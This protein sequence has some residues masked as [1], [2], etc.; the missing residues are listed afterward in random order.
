MP[1]GP[2]TI[3]TLA[4][5]LTREEL[6]N[7]WKLA[8]KQREAAYARLAEADKLLAM[9]DKLVKDLTAKAVEEQA[10][11]VRIQEELQ[12]LYTTYMKG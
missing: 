6:V 3:D 5:S 10:N 2:H 8:D 12:K 4:A 7:F 1:I 9:A 11:M